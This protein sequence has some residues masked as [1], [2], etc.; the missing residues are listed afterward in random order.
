MQMNSRWRSKP[1]DLSNS[2]AQGLMPPNPSPCPVQHISG[3]T[4][5]QTEP[6]ANIE[7]TPTTPYF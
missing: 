5:K 4:T 2:Q 7:L 3:A 1:V 6:P